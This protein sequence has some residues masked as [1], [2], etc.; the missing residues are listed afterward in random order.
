MPLMKVLVV[1]FIVLSGLVANADQFI[2]ASLCFRNWNYVPVRSEG[3]FSSIE[4]AWNNLLSK[5]SPN[6]VVIESGFSQIW[7]TLYSHANLLNA[8][9]NVQ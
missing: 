8:C 7:G 1:F 9:K 6:D 2:C 5:C 4:D 3:S